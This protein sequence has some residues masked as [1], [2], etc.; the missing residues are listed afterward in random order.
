MLQNVVN[1][2]S[3]SNLIQKQGETVPYTEDLRYSDSL[4]SK[5]N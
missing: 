2:K 4:F 5:E 3:K 1:S